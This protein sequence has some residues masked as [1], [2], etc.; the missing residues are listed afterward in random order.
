MTPIHIFVSSVR[1]DFAAE[2]LALQDYV[3]GD[4]LPRRFFDVLVVEL[5]PATNR[6]PDELCGGEVERY[7]LDAEH[8]GNGYGFEFDRGLSLWERELVRATEAGAQ[9][10]ILVKATR[11]NAATPSTYNVAGH[12]VELQ[13]VEI[14][15]GENL[16]LIPGNRTE[17]NVLIFQIRDDCA[18]VEY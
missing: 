2:R 17:R 15:F 14:D 9:C 6:R 3:L 11:R 12:R 10:R 18:L 1:W 16:S 13:T 4:P 7:D 8:F 5:V